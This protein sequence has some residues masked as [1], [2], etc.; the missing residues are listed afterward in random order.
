MTGTSEIRRWLARGGWA[1]TEQALFAVTNFAIN[2]ILARFLLPESYGAFGFALA[3]M[4]LFGSAQDAFLSEC[5]LVLG[6]GKYKAELVPYVSTVLGWHWCLSAL[7]SVALVLL[8]AGAALIGSEAIATAYLASAAATP[9]I[10]YAALARGACYL[11]ERPD[12]AALGG[13]INLVAALAGLWAL[14]QLGRLGVTSA[15]VLMGAA[16]LLAGACMFRGLAVPPLGSRS[17]LNRAPT[18]PS[19]TSITSCFRRLPVWRPGE[20]F[21]RCRCSSGR[22]S[23]C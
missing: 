21:W 12:V 10:F 14:A 4:F 15:F 7:S 23:P 6:S 8:G 13:M 3:T 17:L 20:R 18:G 11:R 9:G 1:M 5:I 19:E 2:L 22:S 16:G